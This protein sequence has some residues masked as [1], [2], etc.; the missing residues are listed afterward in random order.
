[1][2]GQEGFE[3]W[4]KYGDNSDK[5]ISYTLKNGKLKLSEHLDIKVIHK[6]VYCILGV[7]GQNY[8]HEIRF[9]M[10]KVDNSYNFENPPHDFPKA[11]LYK[12]YHK[13]VQEQ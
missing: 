2:E 5:G 4:T 6:E 12:F 11:I 8:Y 13:I 7:I 9:K 1:M 3:E 10:R